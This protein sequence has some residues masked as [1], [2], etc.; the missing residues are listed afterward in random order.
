MK[1]DY[2]HDKFSEMVSD[3]IS[4]SVH[5]REMEKKYPM[6]VR[7]VRSIKEANKKRDEEFRKSCQKNQK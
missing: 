4:A 2:Q 5:E 6:L 3:I 1:H 7:T